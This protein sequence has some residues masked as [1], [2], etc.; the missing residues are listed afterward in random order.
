MYC[1]HN[2]AI[3]FFAQ[4]NLLVQYSMPFERG[5]ERNFEYER[6]LDK[7]KK[8]QMFIDDEDAFHTDKLFWSI[9]AM[10]FDRD[11]EFTLDPS[12]TFRVLNDALTHADAKERG[13]VSE[14][15]LRSLSE[16]AVVE[17]IRTS[18]ECD[19]TWSHEPEN[20]LLKDAPKFREEFI[21]KYAKKMS[22]PKI[23]RG[24]DL[25]SHLR[26][27][28][29]ETP[30]PSGT[31]DRA[32]MAAATASR[33][34]LDKFWHQFR[35]ALKCLQVRKAF[36][37]DFVEQDEEALSAA[38]RSSYIDA[39]RGEEEALLQ[40][41]DAKILRRVQHHPSSK[42][43]V[44]WPVEEP[45]KFVIPSVKHK[46]KTR[47]A[48]V[49]EDS[50]NDVAPSRLEVSATS[51][52]IDFRTITVGAEK[53]TLFQA[54]FSVAKSQIRSY[55]WVHFTQAMADAGCSISQGS[56]SAVH[57]R[58]PCGVIVFHRPHPE[59]HIAQEILIAMG[60][61]LTK[62]FEWTAATFCTGVP[63]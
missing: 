53:Y 41:I 40:A 8:P 25:A 2:I 42:P 33:K 45:E 56:G 31:V 4:Q 32:W 7:E 21:E 63:E 52:E 49:T 39:L 61:R 10:G 17:E 28:H 58:S 47:S 43:A 27:F 5:F 14:Q 15:L 37:T 62:R 19:R 29:E 6:G 38:N 48:Q 46:T 26:A 51:P 44:E 35:V 60:K 59:P 16:M 54:M 55:S 23:I 18:I 1:L 34:S 24:R 36:P 22:L 30:W 13:R 11:R 57:F 3:E 20:E 50:S 12:F 9:R